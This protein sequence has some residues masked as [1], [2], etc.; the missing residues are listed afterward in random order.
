MCGQN[1]TGKK[2]RRYITGIVACLTICFAGCGEGDSDSDRARVP[3]PGEEGRF[4]TA[5][6]VRAERRAYDGAPPIIPHK[7]FGMTCVSCHKAT[8]IELPGVGYAP[9]MPHELTQGLSAIANCTQCH[10]FQQDVK[11][12]AESTFV[13]LRQ[14]LRRGKR[15]NDLA[16]PVIPH[17]VFMRENCAACHTG[18]AA[19]EEIRT[20]HP[21]RSNCK[22]CHIPVDNAISR[23]TIYFLAG[24]NRSIM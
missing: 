4:K 6:I 10:V 21:E 15:L 8:G 9:A 17:P 19:R 16:P 7:N 5:A 14:D 23:E 1:R 20:T 2:R 24:I 18:P 12:F 13:G 3:V 11:P 22:Q